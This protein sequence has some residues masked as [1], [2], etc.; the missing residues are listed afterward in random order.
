M[1]SGDAVGEAEGWEM[2]PGVLRRGTRCG[3]GE[4]RSSWDVEGRSRSP[5]VP[6]L[7][8]QETERGRQGRAL[9]QL[10]IDLTKGDHQLPSRIGTKKNPGTRF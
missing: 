10:E 2:G 7:G 9:F 6:L 5:C 4:H 8:F 1:K 3:T